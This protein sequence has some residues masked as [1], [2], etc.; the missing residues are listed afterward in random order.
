MSIFLVNHKG[1]FLVFWFGVHHTHE[2]TAVTYICS[3]LFLR[4]NHTQK[5][6]ELVLVYD[7]NL[8]FVDENWFLDVDSP[9]LEIS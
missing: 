5:I 8:E 9:M 4:T 3:L 7:E 1:G 6:G 2:C